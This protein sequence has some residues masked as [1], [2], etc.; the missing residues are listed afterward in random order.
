MKIEV[1]KCK[2][3]QDN[4]NT[5]ACFLRHNYVIQAIKVMYQFRAQYH[6]QCLCGLKIME[7]M[8]DVQ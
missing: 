4:G 1:D 3:K 8:F 7:I 2:K 6:L 5:V